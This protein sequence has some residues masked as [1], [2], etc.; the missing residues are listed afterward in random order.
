VDENASRLAEISSRYI[1]TVDK[2]VSVIYEIDPIEIMDE[3]RR[4]KSAAPLSESLKETDQ[5]A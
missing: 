5:D 3:R 4:M 1:N 2:A